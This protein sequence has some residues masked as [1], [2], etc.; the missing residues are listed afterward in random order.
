MQKTELIKAVA[1]TSGLTQKDAAAALN[2]TLEII[3]ATLGRGERVVITGFG[4]FEIRKRSARA[5]V[6]PST[7]APIQIAASTLVG[8]R[9][10]ADLAK[11][12]KE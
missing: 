5:G 2:A 7:H 8:F 6:N 9:P 12:V 11:A 4:T 1:D 3:A 10:G